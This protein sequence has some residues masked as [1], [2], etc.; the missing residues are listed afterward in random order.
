V[1]FTTIAKEDFEARWKKW[2]SVG[3]LTRFLPVSF[4]YGQDIVEQIRYAS[5]TQDEASILGKPVKLQLPSFL[6]NWSEQIK[7]TIPNN[8]AEQLIEP[9]QD[10][11]R[12]LSTYGFRAVRHLKRLTLANALRNNKQVVTQQDI[13]QVLELA[14]FCNLDYTV[15]GKE[16]PP[17]FVSDIELEG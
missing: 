13:D 4:Q 12:R 17:L 11:H 9:G 1:V 8:L 7:V 2:T 6:K 16:K 15:I 5:A 10:M 3:F 14:K